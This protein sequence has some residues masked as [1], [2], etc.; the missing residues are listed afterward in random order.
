MAKLTLPQEKKLNFRQ[1]T[2]V[3]FL[4]SKDGPV[5]QEVVLAFL[6]GFYEYRKELFDN[7]QSRRH[8]H[9]TNA[10]R[11][12]TRDIKAIRETGRY[13]IISN[14]KGIWLGTIE[15]A[16]LY[17]KLRLLRF[18]KYIQKEKEILNRYGIVGQF[19]TDGN[20]VEVEAKE[21]NNE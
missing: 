8:P 11:V 1:E 17:H 15:E 16:T 3:A 12:L 13:T 6:D 5:K 9:E 21:D 4:Q 19:D 20:W 7:E 18:A 2:L 14:D 10:R